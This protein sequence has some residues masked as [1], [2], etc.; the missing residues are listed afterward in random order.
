V[1]LVPNSF[2]KALEHLL[3]LPKIQKLRFFSSHNR[4]HPNNSYNRLN[5]SIR[6][7]YFAYKLS[8]IFHQDPSY[9]ARAGLLHDI[10]YSTVSPEFTKKNYFDHAQAGYRLLSRCNEPPIIREA[11]RTHM[12]PM[13]PFPRTLFAFLIWL[14]DKLDWTFYLLRFTTRLDSHIRS[15]LKER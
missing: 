8:R 10:G 11:I 12:F 3:T 7:A 13:S 5:H 9:C 1:S 14:A 6:I 2:K 4:E 15:L